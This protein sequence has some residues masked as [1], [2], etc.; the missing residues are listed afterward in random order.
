MAKELFLMRSN[1]V[2]SL[3]RIPAERRQEVGTISMNDAAYGTRDKRGHWRPVERLT[4]PDV[5]VWPVKPL[6]ILK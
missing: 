6:A 4:Y 1:L 3:L 2:G 5:F